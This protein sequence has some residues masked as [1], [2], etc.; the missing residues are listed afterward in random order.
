MG[1]NARFH[2]RSIKPII[3]QA[4][5]TQAHI[6]SSVVLAE[7]ILRPVAT[8]SKSTQ[9]DPE[10]DPILDHVNSLKYK[11]R[12]SLALKTLALSK[13]FALEQTAN[14]KEYSARILATKGLASIHQEV[15]IR[16]KC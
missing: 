2:A 13:K 10:T 12:K 9:T 16:T 7:C 1:S 14:H 11:E 3:Q 15:C 6:G 5:K 4:S 8:A